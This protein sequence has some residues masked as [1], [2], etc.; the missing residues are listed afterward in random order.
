LNN[1]LFTDEYL[2]KNISG[3]YWDNSLEGLIEGYKND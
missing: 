3:T 2:N 1:V